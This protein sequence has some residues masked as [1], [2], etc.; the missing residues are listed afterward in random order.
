MQWK[1]KDYHAKYIPLDVDLKLLMVYVQMNGLCPQIYDLH[2]QQHVLGKLITE[3]HVLNIDE[4]L[5][6]LNNLNVVC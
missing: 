2:I 5:K 1:N 3:A 6:N 4:H